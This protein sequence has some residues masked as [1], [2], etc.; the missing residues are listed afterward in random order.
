VAE[1]ASGDIVVLSEGANYPQTP[2]FAA[3]GESVWVRGGSDADRV[4]V[5]YDLAGNEVERSAEF[6]RAD[7]DAPVCTQPDLAVQSAFVDGIEYPVNCG[8]VSPDG[9]FMLYG[10]DIEGA[11]ISGGGYEAWTLD[12]ETGGTTLVTDQLRHCGG[13]D[14]RVG[15]AWSPSGRYVLV[16][17]TYGG[18]DSTMY[19]YDTETG[20]TRPVAMGT[21]VS[22]ITSQVRWSPAEDAYLAP[23]GE[24]SLIERLPGGERTLLP[25]LP[26]PALFD[27]TGELV[28][29][30]GGQY[31]LLP[32]G[33]T[34]GGI[35]TDTVIADAATGEV[36]AVW[37]GAPSIWP[38]ERGVT[39]TD[40]GP[41]ALLEAA[42][43]CDGVTV[44]APSRSEPLCVPGAR[45]PAFD[46]AA[47]RFAFGRPVAETDR[48]THW[49]IVVYDVDA[50]RE[51]VLGSY[52]SGRGRQPPLIRWSADGAHLLVLWSGPDG[53]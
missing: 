17:E 40:D 25:D 32:E 11:G 33:G 26:W 16:G 29:A 53:I 28:Y 3:D 9:R 12:L 41:M 34:A 50:E 35:R 10:V 1:V 23:A 8:T 22:G 51:V 46:P 31:T 18:P 21:Y 20:D 36:V 24:G 15:P 39:S 6:P 45:A 47:T 44:H 2:G 13:C 52:V 30:P 49:E 37:E 4:W 48:E 7:A 19:L 43:G 27:D 5:R 14:G 38:V 42:S